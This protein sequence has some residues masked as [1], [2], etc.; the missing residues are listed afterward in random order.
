M[1]KKTLISNSREYA[2]TNKKESSLLNARIM[3]MLPLCNLRYFQKYIFLPT[4]QSFWHGQNTC[5]FGAEIAVQFILV[6][7]LTSGPK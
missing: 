2:N 5:T 6:R 1:C 3:F 7:S 4:V